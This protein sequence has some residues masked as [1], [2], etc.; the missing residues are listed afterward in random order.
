MP[1]PTQTKMKMIEATLL[2]LEND[3][4]RYFQPV[5]ITPELGI[6]FKLLMD[7]L[8]LEPYNTLNLCTWLTSN[9][10]Q[11]GKDKKEMRNLKLIVLDQ[12]STCVAKEQTR[13]MHERGYSS[14]ENNSK[15]SHLIQLL[16][17][18]YC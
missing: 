12:I 8:N 6:N 14:K 4:L 9:L 5:V 17:T 16:S 15:Y 10:T 7:L 1:L 2:S 3:I 11:N 18:Q 13:G